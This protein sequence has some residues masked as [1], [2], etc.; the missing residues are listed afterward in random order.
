MIFN[1]IAQKCKIGFYST[2]KDKHVS[3]DDYKEFTKTYKNQNMKTFGDYVRFITTDILGLLE[4][5]RN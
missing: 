1:F 3:D 2:F 5:D 4:A